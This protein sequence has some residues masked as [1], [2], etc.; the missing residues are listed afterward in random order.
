MVVLSSQRCDPE[1]T[2]GEPHLGA[3]LHIRGNNGY[4]HNGDNQHHTHDGEKAKDVVVVTLVL[5]Q[6][7]EDEKKLDEDDCEWH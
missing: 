4:F 5:P 7:A 1:R 2:F 3:E 6:A